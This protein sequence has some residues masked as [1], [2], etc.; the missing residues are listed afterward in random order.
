MYASVLTDL[1]INAFIRL[2][3]LFDDC[4][5]ACHCTTYMTPELCICKVQINAY[6]HLSL[7]MMLSI[8]LI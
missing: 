6:S 8:D 2:F 5:C 3:A 1:D 4:L 7:L